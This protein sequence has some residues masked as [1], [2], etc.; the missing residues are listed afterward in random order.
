M[1]IAIELL[2]FHLHAGSQALSLAVIVSWSRDV[3]YLRLLKLQNHGTAYI[4][5]GYGHF[6]WKINFGKYLE[7]LEHNPAAI[8]YY[9]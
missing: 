6:V 9:L 4:I 1:S 5:Y 2:I 8:V 3:G 7:R